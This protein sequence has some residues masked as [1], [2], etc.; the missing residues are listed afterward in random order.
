MK[1][2]WRSVHHRN[3]GEML[4]MAQDP[5]V[6]RIV[7]YIGHEDVMIDGK[8][9][10]LLTNV[11][12]ILPV[13]KAIPLVH[14]RSSGCLR[15][16]ST[17]PGTHSRQS[18]TSVLALPVETTCLQHRADVHSKDPPTPPVSGRNRTIPVAP[19][20]Y[21]PVGK[22]NVPGTG[23]QQSLASSFSQTCL[24]FCSQLPTIRPDSHTPSHDPRSRYFKIYV[25]PRTIARILQ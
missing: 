24:V 18:W 1:D 16:R 3:E 12:K 11:L 25:R 6:M 22:R 9:D 19:L 14:P 8:L 17:N 15:F 21:S 4:E 10:T 2:S 13:G 7:G 5:C 23:N 20:L